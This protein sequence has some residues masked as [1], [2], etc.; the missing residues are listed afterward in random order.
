[1]EDVSYPGLYRWCN[2]DYTALVD[3]MKA[4]PVD[5]P[6]LMPLFEEAIEIWLKEM[7]DIALN[8]TIITLPMN[9]T[10]WTNWPASDNQYV[11]EGF[12]HRTGHQIFINLKSQ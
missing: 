3:K 1:L 10:Y 8:S 7:P 6:A 11:H 9:T 2:E 4:M 12:W 5:D